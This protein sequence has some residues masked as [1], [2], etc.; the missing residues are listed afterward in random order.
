[1]RPARKWKILIVSL[2]VF[3]ACSS[4]NDEKFDT[5]AKQAL[6][7]TLK[8]TAPSPW[9]K[10][11]VIGFKRR[12]FIQ[13]PAAENH[14]PM[15]LGVYYYPD[16]ATDIRPHLDRW[17]NQF[18]QPDQSQSKQQAV[19][20]QLVVNE[21][22]VTTAYLTGTYLETISPPAFGGKVEKKVNYA[23]LAA[24]VETEVGHWFFKAVG[25]QATID[26]WRP[27]FEQFVTTFRFE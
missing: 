6:P 12:T 2:F 15:K 5:A 9:V 14:A 3:F 11:K 20:N 21:L 25:P 7:P 27:T 16:P 13:I 19:L 4:E 18:L 1:M 17:F 10:E 8:Y 26:Y 22:K 23:L 24:V